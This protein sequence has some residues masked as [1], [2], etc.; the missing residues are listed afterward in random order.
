M[1]VFGVDISE[2]NGAVDFTALKNAGVKFVLIRCGY[3]D[4][5]ADQDDSRFFENVKKAQAADIPYGVYLYSYALSTAQAKSEAAHALRLLGQ[6]AKPAYGVWFDMED[7]DGY[8]ARNGMPS[9]DTLVKICEAFCV[10]LEAQG[11]HAGIYAALSWLDN[12]LNDARLDKYDKWVAQWN[13]T[14]DYRKPYG[15]WQY[16]D[17]LVIG[18]RNFDA[19]YAYKDYPA[20]TGEKPQKEETEMRYNKIAD[21]PGY[22][23]PTITKMVKKGFIG[24]SGKAKDKN[25]FPADLDLSIDMIR[26]FVTNDR[27]GLYGK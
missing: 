19:N 9:N 4:N 17:K 8:K 14:C 1:A 2:N 23:Q 5:I 11:Y 25:G 3:G 21:M 10:E 20:L 27:A 6:I 13:S 26:V 18:G 12:Q 22:A 24:G 7:A 16:T 15:I